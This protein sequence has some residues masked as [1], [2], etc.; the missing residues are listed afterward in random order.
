MTLLALSNCHR[1]SN[2]DI[3][4]AIETMCE[5]YPSTTL[6]D[7]YKSCF[8]DYYGVAHL[9]SNR[10]NVK[11]YIDNELSTADS[12]VGSYYE[13][14]GWRGE[15][16]RVNLSAIKDGRITSDCLTDAFM[17][18]ADYSMQH[19]TEEWKAL[20]QK[21]IKEVRSVC[22]TLK[23]FSA[24][25]TAIAAMLERGEYVMHHSPEYRKAHHPHYRIIH[26]SIFERDILP[27]LQ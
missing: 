26:R 6:Q 2:S 27:L 13:P 10:E 8:Q 9:L 18:S 3:R 24:D 25:S 15:F 1:E 21:I 16:I 20:W 5:R 11:K 22:P 19:A 4:Q 12:L 7:I 23:N 14:C 17:A